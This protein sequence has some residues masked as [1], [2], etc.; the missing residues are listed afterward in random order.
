[1]WSLSI[2]ISGTYTAVSAQPTKAHM[3]VCKGAP[4]ARTPSNTTADEEAFR[5]MGFPLR[6]ILLKRKRWSALESSSCDSAAKTAQ[7]IW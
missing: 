1:M 4:P 7:L 3:T 2:T 6:Q 5:R